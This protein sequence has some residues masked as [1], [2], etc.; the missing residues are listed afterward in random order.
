MAY[1]EERA[2]GKIVRLMRDKGFGFIRANDSNDEYFVHHSVFKGQFAT[3]QEGDAVSFVP[4]QG[5]KGLRAEAVEL[6]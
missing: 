6:E 2:S 5:Q 4:S 3:L 1:H